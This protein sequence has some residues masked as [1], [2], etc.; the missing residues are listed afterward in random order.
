MK[1]LDEVIKALELCTGDY[2]CVGYECPYRQEGTCCDIVAVPKMQADALHYLR[3]FQKHVERVRGQLDALKEEYRPNDPLT[4][5][6]LRTM[7]GKPVWVELWEATD[8]DFVQYRWGNGAWYIV[9]EFALG[10][11]AEYCQLTPNRRTWIK[12]SYGEEWQA[13]RKE[14]E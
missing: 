3:L 7:E 10:A 6:E 11:L 2:D 14:R 13:Y 1:T 5:D 4:W 9:K 12:Q 8:S